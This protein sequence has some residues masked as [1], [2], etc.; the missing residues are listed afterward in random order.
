MRETGLHMPPAF[1]GRFQLVATV[2]MAGLE[3]LVAEPLIRGHVPIPSS[4]ARVYFDSLRAT[5]PD[6]VGRD[7]GEHLGDTATT[8]DRMDGEGL[9]VD[10]APLLERLTAV[11]TSVAVVGQELSSRSLMTSNGFT[12]TS[13]TVSHPVRLDVG[14]CLIERMTVDT[15]VVPYGSR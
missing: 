15:D 3:P 5:I 2:D 13:T 10:A 12:P 14:V 9:S 8:T 11:G 1:R 4:F 6:T 7:R